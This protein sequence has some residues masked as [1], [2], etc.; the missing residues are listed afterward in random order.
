MNIATSKTPRPPTFLLSGLLVATA[1]AATAWWV[2]R[3]A[4]RAD[5]DHPPEGRFIEIDGVQ[6][7]YVMRGE[8]TP[9][10]LLH[11]NMVT[12]ADFEVSGLID[13][14]AKDHLVI[15]FDRPGFGHSSRPRD[16]LWTPSAQAALIHRA[17]AQL[18][19]DECFVVGHSMGAM[20]AVALGLNHPSAVRG[21]VLVSGYYYP[22]I[23]IDALATVPV[24]VPVIGD[25][26]RYTVT[27]L[28]ARTLIGPMV[29]GMFA[30]AAVPADFYTTV[31][32]E[33]M[34][35]PVQLRGNAEDATF[36]IPEARTLSRRYSELHMPITIVAGADDQVVD[37]EAHSRRLHAEL[38]H[39]SLIVVPG[40]GHMVHHA[41]QEEIA[42]AIESDTPTPR[43]SSL[44]RARTLPA[45]E[46]A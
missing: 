33:M 29:K 14:L 3:K 37:L 43:S 5:A 18:G 15:A 30:P 46:V 22:K 4:A 39:S 25:V 32:R 10:V 40:A 6:L 11:G 16:R 31:P 9:V 27:A 44:D 13:R 36:M 41:A 17:L 1:A 7:H 20:L 23:R 42:D 12:N 26:M 8:G 28:T 38:P 21:L 24:A 45:L 19:V 34:V 35:R 2:H